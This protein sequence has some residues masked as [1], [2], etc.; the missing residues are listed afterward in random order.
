MSTPREFLDP[1]ELVIVLIGASAVGK[2]TSARYLCETGV[3]E[4]TPTWA[5][6]E[7]RPGEQD[8]SYDHRFVTEEEFDRHQQ[9]GGFIDVKE[10]YGARYGVPRLFKPPEG[11]EA[12]MVLKPV[13]MPV[14]LEHY[15]RTRVYPI[16]SS[17]LLLPD[18]MRER[19]QT[20]EDIDERMRQHDAETVAARHFGDVVFVNDGAI[21]VTPKAIEAQIRADRAAHDAAPV[22]KT[23]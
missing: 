8:T 13:F 6:R 19:G 4:A 7:P 15:P 18:R 11:K 3:V 16:E 1:N 21:D 23:A 12:L 10:L 22:A 5:T 2:S 17:P 20:R 14:F 9:A